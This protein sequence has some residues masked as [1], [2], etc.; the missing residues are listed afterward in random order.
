MLC[1]KAFLCTG[2]VVFRKEGATVQFTTHTSEHTQ[3]CSQTWTTLFRNSSLG[4]RIE[5]DLRVATMNGLFETKKHLEKSSGTRGDRVRVYV[6]FPAIATLTAGDQLF[7]H[8]FICSIRVFSIQTMEDN[9]RKKQQ[10]TL[11][12]PVLSQTWTKCFEL[13]NKIIKCSSFIN[14]QQL[15]NSCSTILKVM[16]FIKRH[17]LMPVAEEPNHRDHRNWYL[18]S[19][20]QS[21]CGKSSKL[22]EQSTNPVTR[23]PTEHHD[24]WC[25]VSLL[26]LMHF[27]RMN[28]EEQSL[29]FYCLQLLHI[30]FHHFLSQQHHNTESNYWTLNIVNGRFL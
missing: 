17:Y 15:M 24:F 6:G 1:F 2:D 8:I 19:W 22:L 18:T 11:S 13:F 9:Y 5:D 23:K 25:Q 26:L 14:D 7:L 4:A 16:F 28:L 30:D 21:D 3:R 27:D 12:S 20:S 29:H 10:K